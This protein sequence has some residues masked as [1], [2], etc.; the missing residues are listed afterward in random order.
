MNARVPIISL[1][2]YQLTTNSVLLYAYQINY[3]SEYFEA[4]T[5]FHLQTFEYLYVAYILDLFSI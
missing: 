3:S 1:N 5:L 4:N 2:I